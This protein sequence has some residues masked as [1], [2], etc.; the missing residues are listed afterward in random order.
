MSLALAQ[1]SMDRTARYVLE[2][3]QFG[4]P[5]DFQLVQ[6][7]LADIVMQLCGERDGQACD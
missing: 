6:R 4:R 3:R 1:A 7:T 2:R 5:I